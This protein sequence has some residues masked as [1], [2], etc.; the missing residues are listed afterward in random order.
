MVVLN[1]IPGLYGVALDKVS[2]PMSAEWAITARNVYVDESG[3]PTSRAGYTKTN[4]SA[5]SGNIRKLFEYLAKDGTSRT[6]IAT[7]SNLYES[8][9]SPVSKKGA[10]TPSA[11]NWKF[12]NFN[13]KVLGWQASHTPIVKSGSGNFANISASSGTLPDGNTACAAFGRVWAV[14]DDKQTI[15]YCAL[16]DETKWDTAD[17][18]GVI[19]MSSVWTQGMDEVVE[20][21]AFGANL[22]VFGKRHIILWTDGAGSQLGIDPDN[23]YVTDSIEYTGA[24]VRD[25]VCSVGELDVLFYSTAGLQSLSRTVQERATPVGDVSP[26]NALKFAGLANTSITG[27]LLDVRMCYH[28]PLGIVLVQSPQ[29]DNLFAINMKHPVPGGG[30]A[31]TQWS[32]PSQDFLSKVNGTLLA[33]SSSDVFSYGG[34]DDAGFAIDVDLNTSWTTMAEGRDVALTGLIL[35][36]YRQEAESLNVQFSF[37]NNDSTDYDGGT[38]DITIPDSVDLAA[39]RVSAPLSGTGSSVRF[40]LSLQNI[41][42]TVRF[43]QMTVLGKPLAGSYGR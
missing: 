15:R 16:L 5:F 28:A 43:G 36:I 29:S 7:S 23:M 33:A 14:D 9:T 34:A 26:N 18:G 37:D 20:I 32:L 13:G 41:S 42:G 3:L 25:A 40:Y 31:V 38:G 6:I 1:A 12:V 10:L 22:V 4:G 21:V 19:D 8:E 39:Y 35:P 27:S 2:S 30:F 24:I 17:G 11:G